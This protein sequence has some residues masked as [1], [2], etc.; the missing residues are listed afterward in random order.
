[1]SR[2]DQESCLAIIS[3]VSC[4]FHATPLGLSGTNV[5]IPLVGIDGLCFLGFYRIPTCENLRNPRY[6]G[7]FL[8][9]SDQD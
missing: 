5:R 4:P 2:L 9:P 6:V 1:M 3:R 8:L 7:Y